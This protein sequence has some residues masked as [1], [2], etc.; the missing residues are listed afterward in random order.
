[1]YDE[2]VKKFNAIQTNDTSSLV[3]K[4]DYNTKIDEIEKKMP[5]QDKYITTQKLNNLTPENV[6]ARLKQ[7]DLASNIIF[8]IS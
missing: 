3:K 4:A 1:M 6:A 8:L 2:L 7:A 5:N